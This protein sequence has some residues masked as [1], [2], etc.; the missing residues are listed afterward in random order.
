[1]LLKDTDIR[2]DLTCGRH[3]DGRPCGWYRISIRMD[4]L[5]RLGLYPG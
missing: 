3:P 2:V 4:M 5:R 1:V